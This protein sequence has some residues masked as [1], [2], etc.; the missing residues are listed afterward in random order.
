MNYSKTGYKSDGLIDL[1]IITDQDIKN[2]TSFAVMIGSVYNSARL[3]K[4]K[5]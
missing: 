2:K 5:K 1:H 4:T 3:L